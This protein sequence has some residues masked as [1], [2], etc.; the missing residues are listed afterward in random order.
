MIRKHVLDRIINS[1]AILNS[2]KFV[3]PDKICQIYSS[4]FRSTEYRIQTV[5]G[6]STQHCKHTTSDP[7]HGND[8]GEGSSG[9]N[10]VYVR[11][12]IM[13][14]LDRN[15]EGCTIISPDKNIKWEKVIL[16]FIDD[17]RQYTNDWKKIHYLPSSKT[18]NR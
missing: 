7:I 10:W 6:T 1:H 2:R 18:F 11:V 9:T 5:L 13:G 17:K 4:T 14:N 16:E 3:V 15:E 12:P 8:Q